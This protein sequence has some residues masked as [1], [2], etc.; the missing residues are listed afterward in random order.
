MS[1]FNSMTVMAA[2][3][4]IA[5]M[6]TQADFSSLVLS[7]GVE[8]FC[9]SGSVASKANNLVRFAR[10]SMGQRSVPTVD[11]N[12]DLTRAMIA[13]AITAS[14][15]YRHNKPD[16][17]ARLVAGLKMDGFEIVEERVP[18]PSGRLSIFD[19]APRMV[20][21]LTLKRMLPEDVPETDFREAEDEVSSLLKKHAFETALGHL[22]LAMAAFQRGEWASA[23]AQLRSFFESYLNDI[24]LKLGYVGK[25]DTKAKRDYLGK[26][27]P[28]FLLPDYNEWNE[29]T[30]KPQYI[31]GLWSRMH[32]EGSHPGLSEEEDA[33]FRLQVTLITARLFLRR[34]DQRK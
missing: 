27:N 19:D 9:G 29:N 4:M 3:E 10:S 14:S 22:S 7:W 25:D 15:Q 18:D 12:C 5:E 32:P 24:A 26:L 20:S 8:E 11:G 1:E 2:G 31:Q 33:T 30:Q 13:H 17:W 16:V 23:N 21:K 6:S 34:F 28:P